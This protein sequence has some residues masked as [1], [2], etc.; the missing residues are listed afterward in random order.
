[1]RSL[2]LRI[3]FLQDF[4]RLIASQFEVINFENHE[5]SDLFDWVLTKLKILRLIYL[6]TN[7]K[8]CSFIIDI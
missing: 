4:L 8:F 2:E 7:T 5:I 1:M 3:I 6:D